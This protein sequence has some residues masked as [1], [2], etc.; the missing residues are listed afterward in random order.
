M[1]YHRIIKAIE[2]RKPDSSS[3]ISECHRLLGIADTSGR[4]RKGV[5]RSLQTHVMVVMLKQRHDIRDIIC[6]ERSQCCEDRLS[7][8]STHDEPSDQSDDAIYQMG[9]VPT[10]FLIEITI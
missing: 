7:D 9:D 6:S 2:I 10:I 8:D 4:D 5:H 3:L 1:L